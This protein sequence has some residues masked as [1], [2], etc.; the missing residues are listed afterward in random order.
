MPDDPSPWAVVG[1]SVGVTALF[2]APFCTAFPVGPWWLGPA[3]RALVNL[4]GLGCGGWGVAALALGDPRRGVAI[5]ATIGAVLGGT[6][7]ADLALGPQRWEG[8]LVAADVARGQLRSSPIISGE[9]R[10]DVAGDERVLRVWGA[11]AEH[12]AAAAAGCAPA[13]TVAVDVLPWTGRLLTLTCL[14]RA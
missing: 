9:L 10:I 6:S 13:S 5:G 3:A 11:H 1:L 14:V 8:R 4:V 12:V 7:W 2:V